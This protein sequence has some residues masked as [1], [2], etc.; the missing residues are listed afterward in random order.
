PLLLIRPEPLCPTRHAITI[1]STINSGHY[2]ALS[3]RGRAVRPDGYRGYPLYP[4][5]LARPDPLPRRWHPRAGHQ[6]GREPDPSDRADP[7]ERPLRRERDRRR[8]LGHARLAGCH[9][10]AVR[11]EPCR[12]PRGYPPGHPRRTPQIPHRRPHAPVL[13]PSVKPRCIGPRRRAYV[14][15]ANYTAQCSGT[16]ITSKN[17]PRGQALG[18][19]LLAPPQIEGQYHCLAP[20]DQTFRS[21]AFSWR[22]QSRH[23]SPRPVPLWRY[24]RPANGRYF[25]RAA[26]GRPT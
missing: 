12:L 22:A 9:L 13:R 7:E 20:K 2:P 17:N 24:V 5:A 18:Q 10:Q 8:E 1:V 11:R 26:S 23:R 16:V 6:P 3:C 15:E 19:V 4:R 25:R 14:S 21:V